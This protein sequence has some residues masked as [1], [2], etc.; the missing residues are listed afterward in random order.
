LI[1]TSMSRRLLSACIAPALAAALFCCAAGALTANS[2][3][4]ARPAPLGADEFLAPVAEQLAAHFVVP[5]EL[6]LD[7]LRPW[8]PLRVASSNW[9][10]RLVA[11]PASGLAS[12]MIVRCR[13]LV[14]GQPVG[15]WNLAVR[16]QLLAEAWVVRQPLARHEP[17]SVEQ[18]DL[19]RVD[20]LRERDTIPVDT[21]LAGFA[22]GRPLPT[23][24]VLSWRDV[25]RRALVRRGE[26]IEVAALSGGLAVTMKAVA[27]QNGTLGDAIVVRNPASRRDFTAT[28]VGEQRAEVRF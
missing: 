12:N 11:P 7:P 27:M 4:A 3:P 5:G 10:V 2:S 18:L 22:V 14:D 25:T 15:E 16:A 1:A 20:L 19:R 8:T 9:E 13:L 21:D 17:L 24:T 23:G 28:V 26:T 6:R